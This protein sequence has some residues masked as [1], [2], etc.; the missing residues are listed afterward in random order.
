MEYKFNLYNIVLIRGIN[1][2]QSMIKATND[3][4]YNILNTEHLITIKTFTNYRE[5]VSKINQ[6][7]NKLDDNS[8]EHAMYL[9]SINDM[10]QR[11]LIFYERISNWNL[12]EIITQNIFIELFNNFSL[13]TSD[14]I[15]LYWSQTDNSSWNDKIKN[16]L[17]VLY[18]S[19]K[20]N[21]ND[22]VLTP[23][24]KPYN[25]LFINKYI[26]SKLDE[27]KSDL[28]ICDVQLSDHIT[29]LGNYQQCYDLFNEMYSYFIFSIIIIYSLEDDHTVI[30]EYNQIIEIISFNMK[31][32]ISLSIL[33]S[34]YLQSNIIGE[35]DVPIYS[36]S[37][38]LF[39][40][41]QTSIYN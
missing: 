35:N 9:K 28:S 39:F 7:S 19:N 25:N 36:T 2:Q 30:K 21:K 14:L 12:G 13:F 17:D 10:F 33:K 15:N 29:I 38:E 16:Y 41:I 1:M 40:I 27:V 32:F 24:N 37:E 18:K 5:T 11:V 8:E 6:S 4:I 34:Q 31:Y 20:K 23:R 3:N 22:I 26:Y